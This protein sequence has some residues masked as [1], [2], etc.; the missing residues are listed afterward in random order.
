MSGLDAKIIESR[1]ISAY[2]IR[3]MGIIKNKYEKR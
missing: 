2:E 1:D 3:D